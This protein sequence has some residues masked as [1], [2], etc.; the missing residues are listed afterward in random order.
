MKIAVD[1]MGGDYAPKA[2]VEGAILAVKEYPLEVILVGDRAKLEEELA[3]HKYKGANISV[4]HASEVISMDEPPMVSIRKK[5]NS[6]L[7][8][9]VNLV[10]E[11]RADAIVS[12]GNTG[13]AVCAASLS[14]R[15]LPGIN[16]PGI[17]I[18]YPTL[19]GNAAFIDVGA[20]IDPKPMDMCA[21]GIMA[22]AFSRYVLKKPN[23]NIGLLNIGEEETKGTEFMKETHKLLES[24][25]LNFIGNVEGKDIFSGHCDVI[26]TDGV[27]GNVVLKVAENLCETFADF[28]KQKLT[29]NIFTKMGALLSLPA[30]NSFKKELDYSEYGGAPLLGVDGVCIISHG[31]STPKAIKNAIRVA[32]EFVDHKVNQH[33]VDR[34]CQLKSV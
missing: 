10:K 20:T 34:I 25:K 21:F 32:G 30:F 8:V 11:K 15:L 27:I 1:A 12:A 4:E 31:R 26:V 24:S 18:N 22:D 2:E 13:A 19:K 16:K 9:A 3:K 5:R 28:L 14:L 6:S 7:V 17:M 33:I 23:P 29:K